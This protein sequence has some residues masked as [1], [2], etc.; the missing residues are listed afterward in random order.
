MHILICDETNSVLPRYVSLLQNAE[1]AVEP[2]LTSVR[3]LSGYFEEINIPKKCVVIIGITS[4]CIA[5]ECEKVI[6][7]IKKRRADIKF[8]L[9]LS[10][11]FRLDELFQMKPAYMLSI[12]VRQEALLKSLQKCRLA[13]EEEEEQIIT[14]QSKGR[15]NCLINNEIV[16]IESQGRC[17]EINMNN[18]NKL[19]YYMRMN[20]LLAKLPGQFVRCH[21]SYGVNSHYIKEYNCGSLVMSTGKNIPIS[22]RYLKEIKEILIK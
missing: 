3:G 2:I 14:L 15:M 13:F 20:D 5:M 17:I 10:G 12:P 11:V 19:I 16:Y 7:V 18:H 22:K 8:I 21:Q 6:P 1:Y 4:E 9:C